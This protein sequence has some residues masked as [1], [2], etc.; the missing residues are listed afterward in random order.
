M[1][2]YKDLLDQ[3]KSITQPQ[4]DIQIPFAP[5]EQQPPVQAQEVPSENKEVAIPAF[6][7][8]ITPVADQVQDVE[9]Q[10]MVD[11]NPAP[12]MP[13]QEPMMSN[14]DRVLKQYMEAQNQSMDNLK[15]AQ[16]KDLAINLI[17]NLGDNLATYINASGERD[18]KSGAG[19]RGTNAGASFAKSIADNAETESAMNKLRTA[20]LLEQYKQLSLGERAALKQANDA[21]LARE[22]NQALLDAARF[23]ANNNGNSDR[24][25]FQKEQA[26]Y[27]KI[28]NLQNGFNKDKQVVKAEE[29]IQSASTL[30]DM[31]NGNPITQ[32]AAKTFAAKASGEVGALSDQDRAAYGGSKAIIERLNQIAKQ[33]STGELTETNKRFMLEL[34]DKFEQTGK[35][36]LEVRLNLYTKQAAK[37]IQKPEDELREII[38][39]DLAIDQNTNN[40]SNVQEIIRRDPKTGRNVRYDSVTKKPLGWAD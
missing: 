22:R 13:D 36:D 38:R 5:I 3:W 24:L 29:R 2:N 12:I 28:E 10:Q 32:E 21:E 34:A 14:S 18:V 33:A 17:G 19:V 23:R 11:E 35:R 40:N 9:S 31:V 6:K 39:P 27:R 4:S 30:R 1:K 16:N 37:R 20:A 25:D 8:T 26:D 7:P 15:S